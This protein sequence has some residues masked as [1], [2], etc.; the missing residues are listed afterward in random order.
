M[1][2]QGRR[3]VPFRHLQRANCLNAMKR[4]ICAVLCI[5]VLMT[6]SACNLSGNDAPTPTQSGGGRPAVQIISPQDGTEVGVNQEV[7]ITFTSTDAVGV[8]RAQLFINGQVVSTLSPSQTSGVPTYSDVFR[9]TPREAGTI[10]AEVRVYRSA[11]ESAPATIRIVVRGSVTPATTAAPATII[12]PPP[13]TNDPTCRVV[14]ASNVNLR[15]GP[16]TIYPVIRV[17]P[18]GSVLPIT[19]RLATNQW[20]Q[21]RDGFNT[22][23][24]SNGVVQVFGN[25]SLIPVVATPPPPIMTATPSRTNT[26]GIPTQPPTVTPSITVTPGLPDLVVTS[27]TG[28]STLT[29]NAGNTPV[30][31]SYTVQ[32]T[33]TGTGRAEQFANT[34]QVTPGGTE[35]SLGVVGGLDPGQSIVLQLDL[36]FTSSGVFTVTARA[37]NSNQVTEVSEV[38]NTGFFSVTVNSAP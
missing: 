9:Y 10:T 19:G 15:T 31:S 4:L 36:T 30:T 16:D 1:Q 13:V 6:A 26:P 29:L 17:L 5:A 18:A 14:I 8:T 27:V 25:C 24:V 12:V 37:D 20:W 32:I 28:A 11:I 22:G 7:A 38:N 3:Y 34:L 35:L 23:W 33:N 21:V 2:S